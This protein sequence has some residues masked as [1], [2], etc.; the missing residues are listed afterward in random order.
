LE[1]AILIP[2]RTIWLDRRDLYIFFYILILSTRRERAKEL[3]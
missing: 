2:L 3:S 1:A